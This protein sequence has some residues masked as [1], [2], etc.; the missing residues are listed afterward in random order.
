MATCTKTFILCY[1]LLYPHYSIVFDHV[2]ILNEDTID[3][4]FDNNIYQKNLFQPTSYL[5]AGY[6]TLYEHIGTVYQNVHMH[7]LIV[8]MKIPTHNDIPVPPQNATRSC[9][10]EDNFKL[11]ECRSRAYRQ[12]RFFNGLFNQTSLEGSHLYTKIFQILHSA[13][14]ALLPN[15]EIKFLSEM[16]HPLKEVEHKNTTH[17]KRSTEDFLTGAEIHRL[18]TYW[19][20]YGEPLPSDFDTMYT[21]STCP[22]CQQRHRD[23]RFISALLKGLHGVT[24]GA[25]IFGRLISSVKKIG[26]YIFKAIH[27]LFH[28]HKVQAIYHAV[29][30]FK[31]YHSKLKI[32]QLFKFKA[33]RDLHISKVSLYDKLNKALHQYGNHMNH[34]IFLRYL[35]EHNNNTWYYDGYED[36]DKN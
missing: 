27:G 32:G 35:H 34:K 16:E 2:T 10:F 7:Y 12:C 28:H 8:G 31:K 5:N 3:K 13:I 15:Q 30:T 24:R 19:D 14:P 22:S 33:Y 1:L 21:S 18:Q 26:G 20:K 29:N 11:T 9:F 6:G 25:S 36:F 4:E 23:K 17:S